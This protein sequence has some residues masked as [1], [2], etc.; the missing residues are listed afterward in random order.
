MA[1]YNE[2]RSQVVSN[3]TSQKW[4]VPNVKEDMSLHDLLY[5]RDLLFVFNEFWANKA[6]EQTGGAF[7]GDKRALSN[8]MAIMDYQNLQIEQYTEAIEKKYPGYSAY[9]PEVP[10]VCTYG[11]EAETV[12]KDAVKAQA[13]YYI[14]EMEK[15]YTNNPPGSEPGTGEPATTEKANNTGLWLIAGFT[16]LVIWIKS[17]RRQAA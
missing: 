9:V 3:D 5:N 14:S 12:C 17:K 2:L 16:A 10:T 6:A 1:N 11:Y 13:A 8:I 4:V 7:S 15:Y